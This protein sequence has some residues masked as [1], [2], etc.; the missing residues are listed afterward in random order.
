MAYR[1]GYRINDEPNG[2][3]VSEA[4]SKVNA[5]TE[6]V[7]GI[8]N[9]LKGNDLTPAE[10]EELKTGK[11]LGSRVIGIVAGNI[12]GSNITGT[13]P[14]YKVLGALTQSTIEAGKVTGLTEFVNEII[15]GG[16]SSDKGYGITQSSLN[17]NGYAK[18]WNGLIVQWGKHDVEKSTGNAQL[19]DVTFPTGFYSKCFCVMLSVQPQDGSVIYGATTGLNAV[20]YMPPSRDVFHVAIMPSNQSAVTLYYVAIGV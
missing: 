17:I 13:I 9:E 15:D 19:G 1:V 20:L 12:D 14:A 2:D 5:E 18:F 6:R 11:I 7:Y 4:F 8:L 3:T 16:G 10:L